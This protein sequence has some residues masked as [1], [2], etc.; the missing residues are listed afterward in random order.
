MTTMMVV[1]AVVAA[2]GAQLRDGASRKARSRR[3]STRR[4][5]R[6]AG[7]CCWGPTPLMEGLSTA[8][9]TTAAGVVVVVP[10]LLLQLLRLLQAQLGEAGGVVCCLVA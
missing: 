10:H 5:L 4:H 1:A 3:R 9:V 7:L 6:E 2:G 8:T